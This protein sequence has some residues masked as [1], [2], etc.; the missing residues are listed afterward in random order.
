MARHRGGRSNRLELDWHAFGASAVG[1]DLA[2]VNASMGSVQ[3]EFA[4]VGTIMRLRGLV[5]VTLDTGGVSESAI[6]MCGVCIMSQDAVVVAAPPDFQTDTTH[7]Q[8]RWLW[9]GSLY[10][11]SAAEAAV[12][13]DRLTASIEIDS[14]AMRRVK[15]LEELVFVH[16][17][18]AGLVVDQ[19]G[20]YDLT[21]YIHVLTGQ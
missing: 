21:Y 9:Q 10:L 6:I 19:T 8:T 2:G 12:A 20:T 7:D 18:P 3:F 4:S 15:P 16:Q 1:Q 13:T 5:G 11:S 14:K 17:S